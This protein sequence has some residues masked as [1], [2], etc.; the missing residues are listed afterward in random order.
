[1]SL[2]SYPVHNWSPEQTKEHRCS[3][4]KFIID[5]FFLHVS[6]RSVVLKFL[7]MFLF[8]CPNGTYFHYLL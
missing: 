6:W 7:N 5:F 4:W 3:F 1:M 2:A 8:F